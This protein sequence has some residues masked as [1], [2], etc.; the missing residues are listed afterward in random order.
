MKSLIYLLPVLGLASAWPH[1]QHEQQEEHHEQQGNI[2]CANGQENGCVKTTIGTTVNT[3]TTV[4]C[5]TPTSTPT[6][7]PDHDPS[8]LH[9]TCP[10]GQ[11]AQWNQKS[12]SCVCVLDPTTY[13]TTTPI[14][15][16]TKPYT[17][18]PVSTPSPTGPCWPATY[19]CPAPSCTGLGV[20][21][22]VNTVTVTTVVEKTVV[23]TEPCSTNPSPTPSPTP[24]PSTTTTERRTDCEVGTPETVDGG[25]AGPLTIYGQRA[26]P[27]PAII[28]D[29][30]PLDQWA[31]KLGIGSTVCLT[32]LH[33]QE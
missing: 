24:S 4:P 32:T 28:G 33:Y 12:Y 7:T 26:L 1:E 16:S 21:T 18:P 20:V 30:V 25:A 6:Q 5:V 15:S 8:C 14:D 17:T 31:K 23:I 3:T 11:H 9:T 27:T 19:S 13:P 22:L 29:Y 2:K 10:A